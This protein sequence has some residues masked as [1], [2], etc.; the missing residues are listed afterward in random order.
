MS[1]G[2]WVDVMNVGQLS[3]FLETFIGLVCSFISS[4]KFILSA[5][6]RLGT[7]HIVFAFMELTLY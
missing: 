7:G 4:E 1:D 3:V 6:Q 5:H 2:R